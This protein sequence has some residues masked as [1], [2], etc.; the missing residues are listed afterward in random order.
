MVVA[1]K[2]LQYLFISKF[3]KFYWSYLNNHYIFIFPFICPYI[4]FYLFRYINIRNSI[5]NWN[6]IVICVKLDRNIKYDSWFLF[7]VSIFVFYFYYII[8]YYNIA[9]H[10]S[11]RKNKKIE[12]A[13]AKLICIFIF[14]FKYYI[15]FDLLNL[16]DFPKLFLHLIL[17]LDFT[18]YF[19]L[20]TGIAIH[21]I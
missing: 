3:F 14:S 19:Q 6:M 21:Y 20:S 18:S 16:F 8:K 7:Y 1:Y 13:I 12:V 9:A 5:L 11:R 15:I 4:W 17:I 10:G 2:I